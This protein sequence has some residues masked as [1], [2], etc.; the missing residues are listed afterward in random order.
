MVARSYRK[1][2]RAAMRKVFAPLL[3]L[4]TVTAFWFWAGQPLHLSS[5]FQKQRLQCVSYTPFKGKENPY[6]LDKG[7]VISDARLEEDVRLL[8]QYFSCVR[9]YSPTGMEALPG[10]LKKYD[11]KLLLGLWINRENK[12]NQ[13]EIARAAVMAR[14]YP[15]V[16]EA[17]IVGNEALLRKEVTG[18]EL[19]S[20]IQ[21]VRKELPGVS[22]TYADVWEFWLEY[23][24]V[25]PAVDFVTIHILPYWENE[26]TSVAAS[27]DHVVRV[28]SKIQEAFPNKDILIGETGWP[29]FGRRREA[30]QPGRIEE[31]RYL[32]AFLHLAQE[33]GWRYNL[34]EAFDQPWK[35]N[36]EGA[37][38]GYWGIFDESRADKGVLGGSVIRVPEWKWGLGASL[39]FLVLFSILS[40][41]QVSSRKL[42]LILVVAI[43]LP[44]QIRDYYLSVRNIHEAFDAVLVLSIAFAS[45]FFLLKKIQSQVLFL[46][47]AMSFGLLLLREQLGLLFDGRY[48]LI[49][50]GGYFLPIITLMS[51]RQKLLDTKTGRGIAGL[52]GFF[53]LI[54]SMCLMINETPWNLEADFWVLMT[55]SLGYFLMQWGLEFER[56]TFFKKTSEFILSQRHL[57]FGVVMSLIA[58][59]AIRYRIME[60]VRLVELCQPQRLTAWCDVRDVLGI[61]I[62]FRLMAKIG[63]L[64]GLL[65]FLFRK[66]TVLYWF[67]L[68]MTVLAL[69]MYQ[70]DWAW[71]GVVVLMVQRRSD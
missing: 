30:A 41:S 54:S 67:S 59:Y 7:L 49:P 21:Q 34:I 48:R 58:A 66:A 12:S 51:H 70:L 57:L 33:K 31:A 24:E 19:V 60:S 17:V 28:R 9:I 2:E 62:H 50:W 35:K 52:F 40:W 20:Y 22:V 1:S 25:A 6:F 37:V 45:A 42:L 68:L 16:I 69:V 65:F 13:I 18:S 4:L 63:I 61:S 8:S 38:G 53:L 15:E 64:F 32:Q 26:P 44:L 56:A 39:V 14:Q 29:S 36:N 47:F 46:I 11:M 23:P 55:G 71:W 43:F 27:M 3:G 5:S 10:I